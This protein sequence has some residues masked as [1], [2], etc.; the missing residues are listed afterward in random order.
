MELG[1]ENAI[2]ISNV[3]GGSGGCSAEKVLVCGAVD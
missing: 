2:S 1:V 3:A